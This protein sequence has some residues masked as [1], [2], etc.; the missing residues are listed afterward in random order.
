VDVPA[1]ARS[2]SEGRAGISAAVLTE[3]QLSS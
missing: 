1:G 2:V 3:Q